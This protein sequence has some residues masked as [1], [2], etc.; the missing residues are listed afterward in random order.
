MDNADAIITEMEEHVLQSPTRFAGTDEEIWHVAKA[1][2]NLLHSLS[3]YFLCLRTK[4]FH[5]TPDIVRKGKRFRDHVLAHERYLGMSTTT[6]SHL[7]EDHSVEQ[8]WEF[9][10]IGNL[11]EDFGERNHQDQAKADRR[12]GCV[13]NF[14]AREKIK[15]LEEVQAKDST[16]LVKISDIKVKRQRGQSKETEA[17]QAQNV[18]NDWIVETKY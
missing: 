3:R 4:R 12:L 9:N 13:Q 16:V 7:M 8:Q 15:S 10:G 2:R 11:G 14:A 6:K 17:R 5:L 1:H 18:K